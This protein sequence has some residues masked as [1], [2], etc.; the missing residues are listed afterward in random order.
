VKRG[1]SN[2]GNLIGRVN[3][4]QARPPTHDTPTGSQVDYVEP[5]YMC[6]HAL[7]RFI[8]KII[9]KSCLILF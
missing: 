4:P 7:L 5:A 2:G 6:W 3:I 8:L 9:L 1:V